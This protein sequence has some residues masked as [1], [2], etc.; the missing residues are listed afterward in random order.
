MTKKLEPTT[1]VNAGAEM[2]EQLKTCNDRGERI[3]LIPVLSPA[4]IEVLR[5]LRHATWDGNVVSKAARD[6]LYKQGFVTRWNG[7]QIASEL[8]LIALET[9]GWVDDRDIWEAVRR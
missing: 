1:Q 4:E 2:L 9:F 5:Q 6:S 8:G 7:W 3:G